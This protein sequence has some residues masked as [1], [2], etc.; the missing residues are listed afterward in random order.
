METFFSLLERHVQ[1]QGTL[2]CVGLDPH[3]GDLPK[4]TAE[5]ALDFCVRIVRETARFAA[6]FKPN[7]A[8]FEA[9]GPVGW[10]ALKLVIE[11][12]QEESHRQGSVIPIILDAKRGDIASTAEAYARSAF[13]QL[14]AHA[15]TLSPYLGRDALE[16]FLTDRE[17]GAFVLC[18]TS[19]PGA[20]EIQAVRV[21]GAD[22]RPHR[23]Y[24]HIA[25]CA[26]AWNTN[27]NL[28]LVVG[29]TDPAALARVRARAPGL[30]FLVPGLGAQGG[31]L[32]AALHAGLRPD[33]MGLLINASR[34]IARA[35]KP[36]EAARDLRDE[37]NA[38]R[39]QR[40]EARRQTTDD[41]PLA[42]PAVHRPSS[43]VSL[44]ED[45]IASQCVKFGTFTLK[46][47]KPS[48]IYLDLRRLVAHPAILKRAAHAYAQVL[49]PLAF[50]R[51]AGLP[52]AALPIGTAVALE[53]NIP[54]VYPRREVKD[55]GTKAAVEGDYQPGE[56][57]VVLDDLATTGGTKL[58][59]IQ[60]LE[61]VGLKVR[62]I[63]VLVDREQGARE[64]LAAAGYRMH[65]VATL[66]E[67]LDAWLASGAV[68]PEQHRSV[69][70][71]LAA[72]Q[73]EA[74]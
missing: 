39:R 14:G 8:F 15:V 11:A 54:L 21:A 18:K 66:R 33:R 67:L 47:G 19:N 22:G 45:L 69:L 68:T 7:A 52:Y 50:E 26:Q 20:D 34:S 46:S 29:A 73:A 27:G 40:T 61:A 42:S 13:Q 12:V 64:T 32:E 5:A 25:D 71:F 1:T 74:R 59:A 65:A 10:E 17:K 30:W 72:E 70:A 60:K 28:G 24:E 16:P 6:A 49:A 23:L 63:V 44:A 41:R 51:I 57:V 9:Y 2:L 62:D 4:P 55:Y 48:P 53:M 36:R 43:T 37:I 35:P 38:L 31:D 58:E 56:T 3:P